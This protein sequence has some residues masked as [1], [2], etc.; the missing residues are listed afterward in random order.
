MKFSPAAF[1]SLLAADPMQGYQAPAKEGFFV[2]ELGQPGSGKTFRTR[3]LTSVFHQTTSF[4]VC[5][6]LI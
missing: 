2:D 1:T 4:L 6:I 3:E 5:Y